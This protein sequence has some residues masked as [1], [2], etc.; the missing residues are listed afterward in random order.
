MSERFTG[1]SEVHHGSDLPL[2]AVGGDAR[3][4]ASIAAGNFGEVELAVPL[5]HARRQLSSVC[6]GRQRDAQREEGRGGSG[7]LSVVLHV[8]FKWLKCLHLGK[9]EGLLQILFLLILVDICHH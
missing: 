8:E 1:H 3:V 5:L 4:V 9:D 7:R 6:R 2:Q